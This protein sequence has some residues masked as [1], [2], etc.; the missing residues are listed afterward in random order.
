MKINI[1]FLISIL[2]QTS[3]PIVQGYREGGGSGVQQIA[4]GSGTQR[5]PRGTS[6]GGTSSRELEY[7]GNPNNPNNLIINPNINS[8]NANLSPNAS[9]INSSNPNPN[10]NLNSPLLHSNSPSKRKKR[11]GKSQ[12]GDHAHTQSSDHSSEP[13]ASAATIF[14]TLFSK[15]GF[16]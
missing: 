11:M 15:K 6:G 3:V 9:L 10:T 2:A 13:V 5:S 7:S 12:S 1:D 14:E 4:G 16:S 8:A